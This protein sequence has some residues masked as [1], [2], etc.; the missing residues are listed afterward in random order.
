MPFSTYVR[1]GL[2]NHVLKVSP[3][4]VPA[5]IYV[6]LSTSSPGDDGSTINEPVGGNYSRVQCN[7]WGVAANGATSNS[8]VVSFPRAT[9]SW[10]AITHVCLYDAASGGNFLGYGT[11]AAARTVASLDQVHFLAGD[12]DIDIA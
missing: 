5:N 10:G 4:T 11:L 3:F 2:L 1:N 12:I 6:A 8:G 9:A 7:N